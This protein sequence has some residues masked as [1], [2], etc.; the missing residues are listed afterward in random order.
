MSLKRI[1]K[2]YSSRNIFNLLLIFKIFDNLSLSLRLQTFAVFLLLLVTSFAEMNFLIIF[3]EFIGLLTKEPTSSN[4]NFL[5][6]LFGDNC[7]N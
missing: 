1:I 7:S 5:I 4:P 3:A 6:S 2:K